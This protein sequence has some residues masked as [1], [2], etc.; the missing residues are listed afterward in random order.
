MKRTRVLLHLVKAAAAIWAGF[1][2]AVCAGDPTVPE[3]RFVLSAYGLP[4]EGVWKGTPVLADVNGDGSLDLAAHRQRGRGAH[5]WLGDGKGNWTEASESLQGGQVECG[6]G[7][8]LGDI[9][10]DG[11]LDLADADHCQGVFVYLGDGRGHWRVSTERL[12]PARAGQP[13]LKKEG[14]NFY[15]GAEDLA[16]GDV[17]E[18]GFL[19]LVVTASDKGGMAVYFGD[20]S[21]KD[22]QEAKEA[23]GLPSAEDPEPGDAKQAGW[24][25]ELLLH[26][27]NGDR[28]LDVVAS[29]Y[30]GPRVWRGD[31]KGHWQAH[32]NGLPRT[33]YGGL[34]RRIA[35][36]DINRDGR[37]D[38][39][40]THVV[41]GP[42]VFLQN[43]DGSWQ[44]A[45]D[46]LPTMKGGAEGIALGDLDGD[47][48]IDVVTGGR[49]VRE[50]NSPYELFVCR[51]DG[52]GGWTQVQG[53]HLRAAG[54][55]I[56]WGIA[57]GDVN[58]DKRLDI[59]VSTGGTMAKRIAGTPPVGGAQKAEGDKDEGNKDTLPHMQVWTNEDVKG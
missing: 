38:M 58:N 4:Q 34:F 53:T 3:L 30:N 44:G 22:W 17:N 15:I 50:Q 45:I 5:V 55:E 24:A 31:G 33:L 21:G 16:L 9:N 37:M 42:Q 7:L 57:L 39:A 12:N 59:A 1:P 49:M 43:A 54:S 8:A 26:D 40:I 13:D 28:H 18:D 19:D 25:N 41:N 46:V 29:Y 35:V 56:I 11:R 2:M 27:I 6:G 10:R 20:G 23:D 48:N 51:G 47:G 14:T 36:A 32:S 52:K